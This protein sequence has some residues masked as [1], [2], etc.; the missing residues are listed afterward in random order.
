MAPSPSPPVVDAPPMADGSKP[1]SDFSKGQLP[2][3][4]PPFTLRDEPVENFR[5]MRVIVIGAGFSGIYMGIRIP[6]WLRN[7]DLVIYEKNSGIGGTWFENRYPGCACD[8]P[9]EDYFA[10]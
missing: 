7:I 3:G 5:P 4:S 9:G 1:V 10:A 6:E 8:I 2:S